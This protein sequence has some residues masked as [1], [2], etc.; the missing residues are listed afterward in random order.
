[1]GS[2]FFREREQGLNSPLHRKFVMRLLHYTLSYIQ[3]TL[4]IVN[5]VISIILRASKE[6]ILQKSAW[7]FM[8]TKCLLLPKGDCLYYYISKVEYRIRMRIPYFV[9][10]QKIKGSRLTIKF[11]NL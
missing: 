7:K 11:C 6:V 5:C 8:T 9:L 2:D 4:Y 10:A 1:M 3:Y